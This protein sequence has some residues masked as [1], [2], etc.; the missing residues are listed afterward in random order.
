LTQDPNGMNIFVASDHHVPDDE[1]F[2]LAALRAAEGAAGGRI[3]TL[4]VRPTAPSTAYG[5]INPTGAGLSPVKAFREKPD[6]ESA[7]TYIEAGYLWNSGNFIVKAQTLVD[8]LRAY[9]PGAEDAARRA[10][11]TATPGHLIILGEAFREAPKVSI[12]YAVM[13]KTER[14]SVLAVDFAWSD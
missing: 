10:L 7:A 12:D 6:A 9:A 4:G 5:Y 8:E 2:R 1:A 3:V 11:P 13:E 14:A